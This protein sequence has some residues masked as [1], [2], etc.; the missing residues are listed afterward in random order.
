MIYIDGLELTHRPFF[1]F[2]TGGNTECYTS[3]VSISQCKNC[4]R[5]Q[6]IG[7]LAKIIDQSL[8]HTEESVR[9]VESLLKNFTF[10]TS[11]LPMERCIR[12]CVPACREQGKVVRSTTLR[13]SP[14]DTQWLTNLRCYSAPTPGVPYYTEHCKGCE[15]AHCKPDYRKG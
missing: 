3:I 6:I 5:T 11:S 13:Q 14:E 8:R 9:T 2:L 7:I 12:D 15:R 4:G 10:Y 1:S